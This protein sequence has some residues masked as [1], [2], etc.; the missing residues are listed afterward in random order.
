MDIQVDSQGLVRPPDKPDFANCLENPFSESNV[1]ESLECYLN[2]DIDIN[3]P[4]KDKKP[5]VQ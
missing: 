4:V 3:L 2:G 5:K 1:L